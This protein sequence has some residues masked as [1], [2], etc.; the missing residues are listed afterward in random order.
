MVATKQKPMRNILKIK[1]KEARHAIRE[2]TPSYS[3]RQSGE[4]R[5]EEGKNRRIK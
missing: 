3:E 4:E 1:S 2:K 5:R